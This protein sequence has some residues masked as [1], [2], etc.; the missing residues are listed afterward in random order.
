MDAMSAPEQPCPLSHD[1]MVD[2]WFLEHRAKV[3]DLSAFLDRLDRSSGGTKDDFRIAALRAAIAILIDGQGDRT[4]RIQMAL[5]DQSS[6]PID[7]APM[8]GALGAP[9]PTDAS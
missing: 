7:A 6:E 2:A 8:Q 5:S 4:R 3:L 1:E 9:L